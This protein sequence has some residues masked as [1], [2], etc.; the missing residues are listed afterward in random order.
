MASELQKIVILHTNDIHS[1][2]EQMPKIATAFR[3]LEA[4][5]A[6]I[7]LLKIDVGDHMDRMRIATDG[8][9]GAANIAIM[10][11][12][13]YHLAVPGNNEGLT[14]TQEQL[15]VNYGR[16]ANFIVLG[17]NMGIAP[18]GELPSWLSS[19]WIQEMNGIKLGFIGVTAY[20][21]E[22]YALLNWQLHEPLSVIAQEVEALAQEVDSIVLL[23]H[24]GIAKDRQ[25]A[26]TIPGIDLILGAHTHHLFEEVTLCEDTYMAA[27]GCFGRYIGEVE[28]SYDRAS[29]KLVRIEGGSHS[30][31]DYEMAS[32]ITRLIENYEVQ[33]EDRLSETVT[34]LEQP[35]TN[36]W[37][38][39]SPLGNLLASGI[40]EWVGAEIGLV[41]AGQL[42]GGLEEG[43]VT[44]KMLLTLCPSPINPCKFLLP[45]RKLLVTL[46]EALLDDYINKPI[47]GFGFRGK[48]LGTLCLDGIQVEYDENAVPHHK[49]RSVTVNGAPLQLDRHYWI[50]TLDMFTFGS[51]YLTLSEGT[52]TEF[53]LPEF[54]RDLL[55]HQLKD[56]AALEG[57]HYR[58]WIKTNQPSRLV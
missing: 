51:G 31:E 4:K 47:K 44:R 30:V 49:I 21:P 22:F 24:L 57:C 43:R 15:A 8:T 52:Q 50:G 23:S 55:A 6:G 54:L 29:K 1:H 40:R 58:R 11:A 28:L 9:D 56:S 45:G 13:G 14:F 3:T 41:N 35:L 16:L 7:P 19:H 38:Q 12:T 48:I 17:G 32:D 27:A 25:I 18:D 42:L 46:E 5:H 36:S 53:F 26:E 37:K 20:Y 39:E 2:Y 33:G 10:N 34:I